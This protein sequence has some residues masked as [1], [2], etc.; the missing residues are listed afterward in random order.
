MPR[1]IKIRS[2]NFAPCLSSGCKE[3]P[4]LCRF[5]SIAGI[6]QQEILALCCRVSLTNDTCESLRVVEIVL[7]L[8]SLQLVVRKAELLLSQFLSKFVSLT[9]VLCL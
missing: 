2:L 8:I 4:F 7:F 1:V 5:K 9:D 6:E 3:Y